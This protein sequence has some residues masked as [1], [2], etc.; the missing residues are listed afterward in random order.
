ML[1]A[2]SPRFGK[3]VSQFMSCSVPERLKCL[4]F[5]VKLQ[6]GLK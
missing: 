1:V 2:H 5:K 3:Q 4:M 6:N